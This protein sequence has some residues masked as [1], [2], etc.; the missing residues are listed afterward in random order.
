MEQQDEQLIEYSDF[1][2]IDL[3]VAQII[4]AVR[5]EGTKKLMKMEVDIGTERRQIVAGIADQYTP[6]EIVGKKIV[7][8]ANLKPATI[9]GVE[10]RG[11]LLAA[12]EGESLALVSLDR[13]LLPGA[14]VR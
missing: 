2:K 6:E 9:R 4:S 1:E 14:K 11:M 8:V 7:L 13:Q 5:V 12:S 3:R 10:S